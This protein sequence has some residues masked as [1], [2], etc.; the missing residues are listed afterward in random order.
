MDSY[1]CFMNPK[2]VNFPTIAPHNARAHD[3]SN[4]NSADLFA[5]HLDQV[6][7][8]SGSCIAHRQISVV[9]CEVETS[10]T[11]GPDIISTTS[12]SGSATKFHSSSSNPAMYSAFMQLSIPTCNHRLPRRIQLLK[13]V[14]KFSAWLLRLSLSG[15]VNAQM[16]LWKTEDITSM[17][18]AVQMRPG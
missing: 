9:I 17:A 10:R 13:L 15:R 4:M 1:H 18:R 14:P 3:G 12:W 7:S 2:I 8:V 5:H 6:R 16:E 11:L